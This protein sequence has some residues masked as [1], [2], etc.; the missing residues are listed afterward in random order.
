MLGIGRSTFRAG[1]DPLKEFAKNVDMPDDLKEQFKKRKKEMREDAE[2]LKEMMEN[3]FWKNILG[4]FL[5]SAGHPSNLFKPEIRDD[6][7]RFGKTEAWFKLL[8]LLNNYL[9]LLEEEEEEPEGEEEEQK[10][11][12]PDQVD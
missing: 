9:R 12:I 5:E 8:T 2:A 3:R 11:A 6:P 4:P 10:E 1:P 7:V